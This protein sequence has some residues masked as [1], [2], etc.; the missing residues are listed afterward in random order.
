MTIHAGEKAA[1]LRRATASPYSGSS[2]HAP[3][4]SS[5]KWPAARMMKE[6]AGSAEQGVAMG[7]SSAALAR[8]VPLAP[9]RSRSTS[10]PYGGQR[11]RAGTRKA[12]PKAMYDGVSSQFVFS[13]VD[14]HPTFAT[15]DGYADLEWESVDMPRAPLVDEKTP[16]LSS[17]I[18]VTQGTNEGRT[19]GK[20]EDVP[21]ALERAEHATQSKASGPS[22][23]PP[24]HYLPWFLTLTTSPTSSKQIAQPAQNLTEEVTDASGKVGA[25]AEDGKGKD[26]N[27]RDIDEGKKQLKKKGKPK[28]KSNR[29]KINRH[30]VPST[31]E[32]QKEAYNGT[33]WEDADQGHSVSPKL[34]LCEYSSPG[35][36]EDIRTLL[37]NTM[38]DQSAVPTEEENCSDLLTSMSVVKS[39]SQEVGTKPPA[40]SS[41]CSTAK[42][43][44]ASARSR[45]RI[46]PSKRALQEPSSNKKAW[47]VTTL[48]TDA[49]SLKFDSGK[50]L[51][52]G[53]IRRVSKTETETSYHTAPPLVSPDLPE[54]RG[55]LDTLEAPFVLRRAEQSDTMGHSN[56]SMVS[57]LTDHSR[58]STGRESNPSL[59]TPSMV[60]RDYV[61][62][63]KGSSALEEQ[64]RE[65]PIGL[66]ML[67]R[68][69]LFSETDLLS[70]VPPWKAGQPEDVH[71]APFVSALDTHEKKKPCAE[72]VHRLQ[73]TLDWRLV[74][75]MSNSTGKP[76]LP[77]SP[78]LAQKASKQIIKRGQDFAMASASVRANIP[79]H[80]RRQEQRLKAK[81]WASHL[82]SLEEIHPRRSHEREVQLRKLAWLG[83]E[84]YV[85]RRLRT[86]GSDSSSEMVVWITHSSFS[87]SSAPYRSK[88]SLLEP[89]VCTSTLCLPSAGLKAKGHGEWQVGDAIRAYRTYM[90]QGEGQKQEPQ[91]DRRPSTLEILPSLR[92]VATEQPGD[93]EREWLSSPRV[94]PHD[95]N[96]SSA[97]TPLPSPVQTKA[98]EQGDY[99]PPRREGSLELQKRT[100]QCMYELH[101][102]LFGPACDFTWLHQLSSIKDAEAE[103]IESFLAASSEGWSKIKDSRA[104]A[105]HVDALAHPELLWTEAPFT[106]ITPGQNGDEPVGLY[107]EEADFNGL[108]TFEME[109][110]EDAM[111]Q[112]Y[113]NQ[114]TQVTSSRSRK[115]DRSN[116]H[117]GQSKGQGSA[118]CAKARSSGSY[119]LQRCNAA[120]ANER[121]SLSAMESLSNFRGKNRHA[122]RPAMVAT[123]PD[124]RGRS[125]NGSLLKPDLRAEE[126]CGPSS[127]LTSTELSRG[128]PRANGG[129]DPK[130]NCVGSAP[131]KSRASGTCEDVRA[132]ETENR[133]VRHSLESLQ[134]HLSLIAA[135]KQGDCDGGNEAS[136]SQ[137]RSAYHDVLQGHPPHHLG[138]LEWHFDAHPQSQ[139]LLLAQWQQQQHSLEQR[140]LDS[141]SQAMERSSSY[142]SHVNQ[143]FTD[144]QSNGV[145]RLHAAIMSEW[146]RH[147]G[148]LDAD[149]VV[150]WG[151]TVPSMPA[152]TLTEPTMARQGD[153]GYQPH[154]DDSARHFAQQIDASLLLEDRWGRSVSHG[155]SSS[156]TWEPSIEANGGHYYT[157]ITSRATGGDFAGTAQHTLPVSSVPTG[158]PGGLEVGR[159]QRR[160][161]GSSQGESKRKGKQREARFQRTADLASFQLEQQQHV[162]HGIL[163]MPAVDRERSKPPLLPMRNAFHGLGQSYDDT[164]AHE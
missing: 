126:H 80:R 122:N 63:K 74:S 46:E 31:V 89:T 129:Q 73:R 120:P 138:H 149:Q 27:G 61:G 23:S 28:R 33:E 64:W 123:G 150:E 134:Q 105:A 136:W 37:L 68:P 103:A 139:H 102:S 124:R 21:A 2:S 132:K 156:S 39:F 95:F 114:A 141:Y 4:V 121:Q 19:M 16:F 153:S 55:L 158:R 147:G 42:S 106:P 79:L 8:S 1:R 144:D 145:A 30:P 92:I 109:E 25:K 113:L 41:S 152:I 11:H 91:E 93:T 6:L 44:L 98:D 86:S 3:L 94:S 12:Q 72:T 154:Q 90:I 59:S 77:S 47:P 100:E 160:G 45:R 130:W 157:P 60:M 111:Y 78:P 51:Q 62:E 32:A 118:S 83:L 24:R 137:D 26:T 116:S 107:E 127:G 96:I 14:Q 85:A 48:E 76:H 53:H 155:V 52:V 71:L 57:T 81:G 54:E 161:S 88:A 38:E 22:V 117:L 58:P 43:S 131:L 101:S 56:S 119:H 75:A 17:L 34:S 159:Q 151:S 87:R 20:V 148:A 65:P 164:A 142:L 50:C 13:G 66:A 9:A 82:P 84:E 15:N 146:A 125:V 143:A 128:M 69:S 5:T 163:P 67:S 135:Q 140:H 10:V 133:A 49:P 70:N 35:E 18:F 162:H 36:D 115:K 7:G 97:A 108:S 99:V 112:D 40:L 104:D 110:V 29:A